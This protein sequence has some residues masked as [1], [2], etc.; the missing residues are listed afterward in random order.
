MKILSSKLKKYSLSAI[1]VG[2][3]FMNNNAQAINN[4]NTN[5]GDIYDKI[6]EYEDR[7]SFLEKQ[8]MLLSNKKNETRTIEP[9]HE[10]NIIHEEDIKFGDEE[11]KFVINPSDEEIKNKDNRSIDELYE[12]SIK[13][14]RLNNYSKSEELLYTVINFQDKLNNNHEITANAHYLMGE[15]YYKKPDYEKSAVHFLKSYQEFTII[16][17]HHVQAANSL[18]K[19]AVAL[20]LSGNSKAACNSLIKLNK[21]FTNLSSDIQELTKNELVKYNCDDGR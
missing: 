11:T 20:N 16:S 18:L 9:H 10:N 13:E 3:L 4:K 14:F 6:D 5:Q 15:I 7:I 21:E 1:F 12:A 2:S 19:L 8:I 17:K